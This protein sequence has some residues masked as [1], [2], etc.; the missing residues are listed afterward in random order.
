MQ[1]NHPSS[2]WDVSPW[3]RTPRDP[4]AL[5]KA[6]NNPAWPRSSAYDPVWT[7][8]NSMGPVPIWLAEDLAPRL[9][10][11]PGMR[12]LDLGCGRAATSIFLARE[13]GVE[14]VAADL[15]IDAEGNVARI[16]EAGLPDLVTAV[17]AEARNLPF[18]HAIFDA[19]ISIDAWHYF[20]TDM[21][22][23]SYLAQFVKPGGR[24]GAAMPANRIDPDDQDANA[25]V[26]SGCEALGADWY[27]FRSPDWW[28]RH[29][30]RTPGICVDEAAMVE[31]GRDDWLRSLDAWEA[32]IGQPVAEQENGKQLLAPEGQTLGLCRIVATKLGLSKPHLGYGAYEHRIA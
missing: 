10:L 28:A 19:V 1:A 16:A 8:S 26:S 2:A 4:E 17:H 14:V 27:T 30:A 31:T 18:E 11:A 32:M 3:P 12:V 13:Y 21:R 7:F 15:W 5:A 6:M 24:V 23:L 20:G 25:P 29:W 22:Y 9:G